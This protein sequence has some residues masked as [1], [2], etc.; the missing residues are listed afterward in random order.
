MK[1]KVKPTNGKTHLPSGK[2]ITKTEEVEKTKEIARAI[3]FGDLEVVET[4][5]KKKSDK[6]ES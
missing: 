3:R 2:V 1:I 4:T 5:V 6:G